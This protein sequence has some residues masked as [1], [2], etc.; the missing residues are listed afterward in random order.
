[1]PSNLFISIEFNT[2]ALSQFRNTITRPFVIKT[3]FDMVSKKIP[4]CRQGV[5]APAAGNLEF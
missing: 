1:V 5:V 2:N 3:L 4:T